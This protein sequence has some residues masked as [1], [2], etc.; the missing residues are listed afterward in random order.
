MWRAK[1]LFEPLSAEY[2][3]S[4]TRVLGVLPKYCLSTQYDYEVPGTKKTSD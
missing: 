1:T 3:P 4:I 2:Y